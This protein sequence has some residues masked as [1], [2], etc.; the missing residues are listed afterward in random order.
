[1]LPAIISSHSL[2]WRALVITAPRHRIPLRPRMLA[3]FAVQQ[4]SQNPKALHLTFLLSGMVKQGGRTVGGPSIEGWRHP[5]NHLVLTHH[6]S[7]ALLSIQTHAVVLATEEELEGLP[8]RRVLPCFPHV[9]SQFPHP[10]TLLYNLREAQAF[11]AADLRAYLQ[12]RAG[13]AQG[14]LRLLVCVFCSPVSNGGISRVG[15]RGG[16]DLGRL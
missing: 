8:G 13:H 4:R 14:L 7:V 1:M 15:P 16:P 11:S 3:T 2:L 5:S 10:L 6:P 12:Y 9:S